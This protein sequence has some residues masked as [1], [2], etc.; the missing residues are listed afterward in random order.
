MDRSIEYDTNLVCD[1]CGN[2][3]A[4]DFLGDSL[5]EYCLSGED[6]STISYTLACRPGQDIDYFLQEVKTEIW[7]MLPSMEWEGDL[8]VTIT[9]IPKE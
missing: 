4:Y 6:A 7:R 3:G 9:Y 1:Y 2:L 8:K 5:C